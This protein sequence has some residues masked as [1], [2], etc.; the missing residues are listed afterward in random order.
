MHQWCTG[1][2]CVVFQLPTLGQNNLHGFICL[3][4]LELVMAKVEMVWLWRI[5]LAGIWGKSWCIEECCSR[6]LA[7]YMGM[8]AWYRSLRLYYG[9]QIGGYGVHIGAISWF[10]DKNKAA[11]GFCI[12]LGRSRWICCDLKIILEPNFV[13]ILLWLRSYFW[14]ALATRIQCFC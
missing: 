6:S 9:P 7:S 3:A 1:C 11:L 12:Y 8:K 10:S 14:P 5:C 4:G 2:I 13:S